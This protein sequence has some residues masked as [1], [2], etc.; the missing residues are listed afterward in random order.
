MKEMTS[1]S[2]DKIILYRML[3]I[4]FNIQFWLYFFGTYYN[5]AEIQSALYTYADIPAITCSFLVKQL[6]TQ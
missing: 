5:I 2:K 4:N 1:T 6:L 3:N